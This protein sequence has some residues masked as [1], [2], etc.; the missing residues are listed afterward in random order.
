MYT[1]CVS[2]L[3]LVFGA[4]IGGS[5]FRV[6]FLTSALNAGWLRNLGKYSYGMYVY[7]L[8]LFYGIEHT[9]GK[10]LRVQGSLPNRYAFA[11]LLLLIGA[12][13]LTACLSFALIE[14]PILSLKRY[15]VARVPGEAA[16]VKA[17]FRACA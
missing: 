4:L 17:S 13:Y 10:V 11:E 12:T 8:P 2:G 7:H 1:I 16:A 5:Q 15:F 6:P 3:A 14:R 9:T